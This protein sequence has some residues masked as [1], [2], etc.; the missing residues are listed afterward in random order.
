MA[1]L[2]KVRECGNAWRNV[3]AVMFTNLLPLLYMYI[4][5]VKKSAIAY[6]CYL[7]AHEQ[8]VKSLAFETFNSFQAQVI[9]QKVR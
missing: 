6:P 9:K 7:L 2:K 8:D 4:H 3:M 5:T 1:V